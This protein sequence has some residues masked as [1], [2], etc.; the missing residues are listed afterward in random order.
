MYEKNAGSKR[1]INVLNCLDDRKISTLTRLLN[2]V[3]E[4]QLEQ[5]IKAL[6][7]VIKEAYEKNPT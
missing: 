5:D 6:S 2:Y 1:L 4:Q 3:D 7:D